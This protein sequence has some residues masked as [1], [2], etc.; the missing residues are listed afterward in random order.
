[1]EKIRRDGCNALAREKQ[2]AD[3]KL[4]MDLVPVVAIQGIAM[5]L[6][7]GTKKRAEYSWREGLPYS[8]LYAKIMRHLLDWYMG[9]DCDEESGLHPLDHALADLAILR[10]STI[11]DFG[12]DDRWKP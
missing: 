3:G 2:L 9:C 7:Y 5:A 1:M 6:G 12:K 4:R 10:E 11:F 8:M